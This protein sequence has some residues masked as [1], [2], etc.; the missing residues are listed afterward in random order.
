MAIKHKINSP[1]ILITSNCIMS[2]KEKEDFLKH[3]HQCVQTLCNVGLCD[4]SALKR[5][6]LLQLLYLLYTAKIIDKSYYQSLFDCIEE[7]KETEFQGHYCGAN[8]SCS[9]KWKEIIDAFADAV[10]EL[11]DFNIK[12]SKHPSKLPAITPDMLEGDFD[13]Y[14]VAAFQKTPDSSIVENPDFLRGKDL[15]Y[16]VKMLFDNIKQRFPEL[17]RQQ[18]SILTPPSAVFKMEAENP[19]MSTYNDVDKRD[20]RDKRDNRDEREEDLDGRYSQRM[21]ITK[22]DDNFDET[23]RLRNVTS[24][25][26]LND[27]LKD[28]D[29]YSLSR[30][31]S[32]FRPS[33]FDEE[34]P[35]ESIEGLSL[36]PTLPEKL[37]RSSLRKK[38]S[39]KSLPWWWSSSTAKR[40]KKKSKKKSKKRKTT[41]K[42]RKTVKKSPKNSKQSEIKKI[43]IHADKET[44]ARFR[45]LNRRGKK[46]TTKKSPKKS[47][48]RKSR[49]SNK[50]KL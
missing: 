16:R 28:K 1:T 41:T 37:S 7:V 6:G 21:T 11:K 22:L 31:S 49:K 39:R 19:F 38:R 24:L 46:S 20:E 40:P 48:R 23:P 18:I 33:T 10:V 5:K 3:H 26:E 8:G 35:R 14:T 25:P 47:K 45:D 4:K 27:H 34:N 32:L 2:A 29:S 9:K 42:K 15:H 30:E 12:V 17:Q 36:P 44:I 50:R 13:L 43:T